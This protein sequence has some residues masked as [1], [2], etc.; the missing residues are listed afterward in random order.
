MVTVL[1]TIDTGHDDM[2]HDAQVDFY[3]IKLSICSS[4]SYIKIFDFKNG[5]QTQVADLKGH[6]G[7]VWQVSW[8]T[9][10]PSCGYDR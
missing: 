9:N 7:P 10:V 2:I 1:N 4:D 5:L 3:G 8:V 6:I